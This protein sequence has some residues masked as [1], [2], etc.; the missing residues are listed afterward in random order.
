MAKTLKDLSR[1][2]LMNTIR[3]LKFAALDLNL[4]L[5]THPECKPALNDYN[6]ITSDLKAVIS[7]YESKYA[8]LT[9]FGGAESKYPWAWTNEPWPW[10]SGE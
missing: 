3:E 5:D 2:E 9:N 10:E 4:Y 1:E 6:N 7:V 8:P